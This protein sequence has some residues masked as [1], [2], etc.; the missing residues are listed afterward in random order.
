LTQLGYVD[1]DYSMSVPSTGTQVDPF[2][3]PADPE[4]QTRMFRYLGSTIGTLQDPKA[5]VYLR[6]PNGR[7]DAFNPI[8]LR[9]L[10]QK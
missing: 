4:A 8:Q 7:V 9:G 2:V 3:V 5:T 10:V 6:M 1:K